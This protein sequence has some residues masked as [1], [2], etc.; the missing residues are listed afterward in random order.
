M[1]LFF[2]SAIIR[3]I[4][5][6]LFF[7]STKSILQI[8]AVIVL[9]VPIVRGNNRSVNF[10][11]QKINTSNSCAYFSDKKINTSDPLGQ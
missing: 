11:G 4:I 9:K 8:Y 3:G 6:W 10:V 2:E 1:R 7:K 5:V